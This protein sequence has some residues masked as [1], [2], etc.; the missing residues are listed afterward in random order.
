MRSSCSAARVFLSRAMAADAV[1]RGHDVTCA[2]ARRRAARCPTARGT[3]SGTGPTTCRPRS[4]ARAS[5]PSSTSRGSRRTC[6]RAVAAL[7]DAHWVFVSTVNVYA[8]NE[9][10]D[11]GTDGPLR[12]ADRPTTATSKENPE[13]YGA[14]EGRVRAAGARRRGVVD[15]DPARADRRPGRPVRPLHLL[16]RA[17]R[18][19]RR[20]AG[21]RG[22]D[23]RTQIIDVRDLAEW[24]VRSARVGARPASSTASARDAGRRAPGET[25]DGVGGSAD[26]TWPG[27]GV[28]DGA[29]G[30]AL[31]GRR[32][33]LPLWLPRPEYDGMMAHAPSRPSTAGLAVRPVADTARDT[34]AWLRETPDATRTGLGR[35]RRPRCSPPGTPAGAAESAVVCRRQAARA[36]DRLRQARLR[37]GVS[38]RAGDGGLGEGA[39]RSRGGSAR[40]GSRK[41]M[42]S[43]KKPPRPARAGRR[44]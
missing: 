8:D 41:L 7:P 34:L 15:G 6:A 19:R 9:A 16:A 24:I 10:P 27:P 21:A 18:R 3:W 37:A 33:R 22:A 25:A 44:W 26:V 32:A 2:D 43:S 29:G 23:D 17:A 42:S 12:R 30:R 20:G 11:P 31:G 40:S 35:E 1:A 38:A 13:A 14:H 39:L 5:T 28:P 4:P 36:G